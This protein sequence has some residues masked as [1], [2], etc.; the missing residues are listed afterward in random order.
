[1]ATSKI[2]I[3]LE[4]D[5]KELQEAVENADSLND[6]AAVFGQLAIIGRAKKELGDAADLLKQ[7][8]DMAKGLINAKAKALYGPDWTAIEGPGYKIT[9]SGTGSVYDV[10][11]P[12]AAEEFIEVEFKPDAKAIKEYEKGHNALPEGIGYNPQ[13]GES[14]RITVK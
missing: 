4:I 7:V 10:I 9:R 14:I 6:N 1:M 2:S 3:Q 5:V 12:K 11:D 13:R 8:E